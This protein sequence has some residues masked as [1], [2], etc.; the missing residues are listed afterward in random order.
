MYAIT[1][2]N[3]PEGD[4]GASGMAR[5][6]GL[7]PGD[8]ITLISPK[9]QATAVGTVPRIRAY[10]VGAIFQVGMYQFDNGI[11]LMPLEAAHMTC[12]RIPHRMLRPVRA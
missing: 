10:E 7:R 11:V 8:P 12:S 9:G 2:D 3:M 5:R 1:R 6:M 4:S